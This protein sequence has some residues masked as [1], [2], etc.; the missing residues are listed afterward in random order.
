M[1]YSSIVNEVFKLWR[2]IPIL[3]FISIFKTPWFKG[4]LDEAWV[5]LAAKLRLPGDTYRRLHNVTLPT[6]DGTTQ[7]DHVFVSRFGIFVVE[8][9]NMKGWILG[10]ESL[11]QWTQQ[12]FKKIVQIPKSASPKLQARKSDRNRIR[13]AARINPF[14][15]RLCWRE[16][17][18][19]A[20]AG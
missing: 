3:L 20:H 2:V 11:A 16:H 5:K 19:I 10:G 9:K 18:Q 15:R 14:G 8:A 13:C 7:V 1:D 17:V 4:V 12:V 6:P